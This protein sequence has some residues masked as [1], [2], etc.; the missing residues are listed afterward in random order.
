[1][2][3]VP[4]NSCRPQTFYAPRSP[5]VTWNITFCRSF[6]NLDQSSNFIIWKSSHQYHFWLRDQFE[7]KLLCFRNWAWNRENTNGP[8]CITFP[9]SVRQGLLP[10][11]LKNRQTL[12]FTPFHCAFQRKNG[13]LKVQTCIYS[14]ILWF[15]RDHFWSVC[16]ISKTNPQEEFNSIILSF[17]I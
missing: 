8:I 13:K 14:S 15:P 2:F 17:R 3:L 7:P 9:L 1:M 5:L 6:K 12:S 11:W 10:Y 4:V 16:F